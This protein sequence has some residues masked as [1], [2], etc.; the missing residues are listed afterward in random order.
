MGRLMFRLVDEVPLM[1]AEDYATPEMLATFRDEQRASKVRDF[2]P[3]DDDSPQM[4]EVQLPPNQA[5]DPH[6]HVEDEIMYVIEGA[7]VFGA[8]LV[9]AGSAVLIDRRTLYSFRAGPDGVRMLNF[10]PRRD[11]SYLAKS[12]VAHRAR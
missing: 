2:F 9:P 4:F 11:M 5:V 3:G 7:L 12:E 8:R 6:A 10:R 1:R